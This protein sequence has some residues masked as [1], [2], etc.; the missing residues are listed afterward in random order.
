[1][2]KILYTKKLYEFVW[3]SNNWLKISIVF[4][5]L[6][7]NVI[8]R[9]YTRW[10]RLDWRRIPSARVRLHC[11]A[12]NR[13]GT[14]SRF[15]DIFSTGNAPFFLERWSNISY[16]RSFNPFCTFFP[17]AREIVIASLRIMFR[18]TAPLP[19]NFYANPCASSVPVCFNPQWSLQAS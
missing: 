4:R 11:L 12:R 5:A 9:I 15:R 17:C 1:M 2:I 13:S 14:S 7:R 6:N 3:N 16:S 19:A 18:V 10:R 8:L